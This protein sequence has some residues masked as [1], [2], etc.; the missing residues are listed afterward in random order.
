M[1]A[2]TNKALNGSVCWWCVFFA[3]AFLSPGAVVVVVPAIVPVVA[4]VV[5]PAPV[6]PVVPVAVTA[7]VIVAAPWAVFCGSMCGA[8]ADCASGCGFPIHYR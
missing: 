3:G 1:I 2:F 7:V 6:L 8:P 4:P 5:A